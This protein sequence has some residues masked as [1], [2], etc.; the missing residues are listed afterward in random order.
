MDKHKKELLLAKIA[1]LETSTGDPVIQTVCGILKDM[2][3][4][5]DYKDEMGFKNES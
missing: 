2:V 1:T 4:E 5:F 3:T